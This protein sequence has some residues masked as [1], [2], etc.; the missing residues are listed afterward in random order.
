M[1]SVQFFGPTSI[2]LEDPA[3]MVFA[4]EPAWPHGLVIRRTWP[5]HGPQLAVS[6]TPLHHILSMGDPN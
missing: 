4:A 5:M 6:S 1:P 2:G 3:Q